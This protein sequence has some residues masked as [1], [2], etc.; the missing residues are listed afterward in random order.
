MHHLLSK[1]VLTLTCAL[2]LD[3]LSAFSPSSSASNKATLSIHNNTNMRIHIRAI[4]RVE[5]GQIAPGRWM[6]ITLP[7]KFR[8]KGTEYF[9]RD[10]MAYGGGYWKANSSGWTRYLNLKTC[11]KRQFD[12]KSGQ[13]IW[14]LNGMVKNCEPLGYRQ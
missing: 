7:K 3:G 14:K 6:H 9:T 12:H 4:G 13:V 5:V 11:E 8:Y 2:A 10:F 1:S